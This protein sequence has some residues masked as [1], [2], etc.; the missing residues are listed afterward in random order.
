[1]ICQIDEMNKARLD[2]LKHNHYSRRIRSHY[3]AYGTSYDF[4]RFFEVYDNGSFCG[5]ISVFNS[6]MMIDSAEN[7]ELSSE[8][9][10]EIA[11]FILMNKPASVELEEKYS[12]AVLSRVG[13]E[14]S[15]DTRTEFEFVPRNALPE[16]DVD[17]LPKLD[18][19]FR[20]LKESFPSLAESYELWLT[21]TSHR[22]R[23]GLSQSFLLGDYS[24]ATI[25]YIIDGIA[26]IGHVATIP[27]ERGKFHARTLLYWIG[28]KLTGDGFT[29]KLFARPH[30][31]SYYEEIGFK[32]IGT[33]NVLERKNIDD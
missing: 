3:Q 33:D 26:L 2:G 27:E 23:R 13:S 20:I 29:V 1:M 19:V 14:Y 8:I 4:A 5:M 17:E 25:Q 18:D 10:D 31:V 28:E 21:D 15:S 30:R 9:I 32:E 6:S 7:S 22:I 12:S 24:T 11:D 16:L